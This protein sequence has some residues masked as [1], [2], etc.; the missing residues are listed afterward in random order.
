MP[1]LAGLL[2]HLIALDG[3]SSAG[4]ADGQLHRQ[5]RCAHDNQEQQVEKD[6][7]TA[8][9]QAGNERE[10]PDIADTDCAS[11][12]DQKKAEAGTKGFSFHIISSSLDMHKYA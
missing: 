11:R 2:K 9:V 1:F 12:T 10:L 5:N 3:T 7:D 4:A 8:A 6:E